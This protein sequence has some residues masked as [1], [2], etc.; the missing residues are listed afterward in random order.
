MTP[1]KTKLKHGNK[2]LALVLKSHQETL[3]VQLVADWAA[4]L[5]ISNQEATLLVNTTLA[6]LIEALDSGATDR[7][8]N[9]FAEWARGQAEKGLQAE[10]LLRLG[11]SLCWNT[12]NV[13]E[14]AGGVT[15]WL[16]EL[17]DLIALAQVAAVKAMTEAR[18]VQQRQTLSLEQSRV[19]DMAQAQARLTQQ[20]RELSSPVIKV[21]EEVLI[22][23]L[24]GSID[25][26]RATRVMED[27]LLGIVSHQAEIV[28]IDVT[29]VPVVDTHVVTHLVQ[30]VK[31]ASLLGTQSVLVGISAE[32]AL[33]MIHLGVDLNEIKTRRDLQSGIEFALQALDLQVVS[34]DMPD[35][36][37][38]VG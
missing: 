25:S 24:V 9:P 2:D 13:V 7:L 34:K 36:E 12:W 37:D 14:G 20:I 31:A 11:H 33:S 27:L 16:R 17:V 28:I 38:E 23:P 29:G 22:L 3:S 6:Q 15:T 30:T 21:W 35:I 8:A 4:R 26:S 10:S 1:K 32:V 18:D 19:A 5:H